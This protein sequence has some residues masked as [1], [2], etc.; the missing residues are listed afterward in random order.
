MPKPAKRKSSLAVV[1]GVAALVGCGTRAAAPSSALPVDGAGGQVGGASGSS[2]ASTTGGGGNGGS[3]AMAGGGSTAA[4]A[5]SVA[6]GGAAAVGG[7]APLPGTFLISKYQPITI[8]VPA[9]SAVDF[10]K[11][12]NAHGYDYPVP[13][14][15]ADLDAL[16]RWSQGVLS[17]NPFRGLAANQVPWLDVNDSTV[18]KDYLFITQEQMAYLFLI[19]LFGN[20][21]LLPDRGKHTGLEFTSQY[22]D[23]N[24]A[25]KNHFLY[26]VMTLLR[27]LMQSSAYKTTY[28]GL[29]FGGTDQATSMDAITS[30]LAAAP[31]LSRKQMG[32]LNVCYFDESSLLVKDARAPL[33][34]S[35]CRKETSLS[36][37]GASF[38]SLDIPG[39]TVVD[40]GG[41]DLGGYTTVPGAYLWKTQDESI[42]T[43]YPETIV[44]SFFTLEKEAKPKGTPDTGGKLYLLDKTAMFFGVRHYLEGLNGSKTL[45]AF[46]YIPGDDLYGHT[47]CGKALGPTQAMLTDTVQANV[48]G[49]KLTF[50]D[51]NLVFVASQE[52]QPGTVPIALNQN[53]WI[54]ERKLY[55]GA[56]FDSNRWSLLNQNPKDGKWSSPLIDVGKWWSAFAPQMY[57]ADV[58]DL[59]ARSVRRIGSFNW[60]AGA[61]WGDPEQ[62][63]LISWLGTSLLDDV[64]LDYYVMSTSCENSGI[65]TA[66]L[67]GD[68]Y[69]RALA[70][71][72]ASPNP[73]PLAWVPARASNRDV[74]DVHALL[75]GRTVE[76]ALSALKTASQN[77]AVHVFEGIQ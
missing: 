28:I 10:R 59:F 69:R 71:N 22:W 36:D 30:K 39:Q 56:S 42:P 6:G 74:A 43:F 12:M 44:W 60:G 19:T 23:Q 16:N 33:A 45:K 68:Q 66:L 15:D 31:L 46:D 13:F 64:T 47:S 20:D 72:Q 70:L 4:G 67:K 65:Q 73:L 61:W 41:Y 62:Y 58:S 8:T 7:A 55:S 48:A 77:P 2:G 75:Q 11:I 18:L 5:A 1:C 52:T 54:P 29:A 34:D 35:W 17:Q 57:H 3:I 24:P 25:N 37:L 76:Q 49:T 38:H 32:S 14:S 9:A 53:Y 27:S 26:S 40:I 51:H 63:F 50:Y 21:D